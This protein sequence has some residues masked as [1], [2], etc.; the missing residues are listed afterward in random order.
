MTSKIP[1]SSFFSSSRKVSYK[2]N[3]HTVTLPPQFVKSLMN[4]SDRKVKL[5]CIDN[6]LMIII[7]EKFA[8][9]DEYAL[10]YTIIQSIEALYHSSSNEFVRR[11]IEKIYEDLATL[12][13]I[14]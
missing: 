12:L 7:P 4:L 13:N 3:S 14:L 6:H 11:Q 2:G 1:F 10:T 5:L 9:D 8:N